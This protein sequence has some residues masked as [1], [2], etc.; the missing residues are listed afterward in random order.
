VIE[1]RIL[2]SL[3]VVDGDHQVALGGPRQRAL[4]TVLLVHRNELVSSDRLI[5]ELWSERAP[6]SAIKVVQGYVSNLR[7]VL[8]D[9]VLVTRGHGYLLRADKGQLDSDRFESLAAAGRRALHEG[10]ARAAAERLREALALW[11]GEPLADCAY[12]TFA[13]PE[14]ARLGESR[15]AAL[16]DRID[17]E[18][19]LGEHSNLVGEL[20]ALVHEHPSR[21]RFESQLMLALYRSGRQADALESYR[22]ARGRM[23]AELGIAPG[24]GLQQL[25][26]AIL[27]HDPGLEAP[28]R[29]ARQEPRALPRPPPRSA[30]VLAAGVA[31]LLAAVALITARL[32]DSGTAAVRAGPN[33][34]AAIDPRSNR[35]V[36]VL[37][38]GARPAGVV[39][40]SG[41]LWVANLD[42]Q[43]VSRI[44]PRT[45]Q[46]LRA[47]VIG[48]PPTAIAATAHRVWVLESSPNPDAGPG[49][50]S[51][52]VGRVDPEFDTLSSAARIRN[53]AQ[54]GPGALAC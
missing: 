37:S 25:E 8:G 52:L 13:Q 51:V 30:A 1:F 15:M 4:L 19:A 17:A 6:P 2:G 31:I 36:D 45:L 54:S 43:T 32:T 22:L 50:T 39:F 33:S 23:A 11:R 44:D 47:I 29:E 46:T 35:V 5:D 20:E 40:G 9:G 3:E 24:R 10:D 41:S 14:I 26:R 21:E 16:E 34:L 42:D 12:D 7:K 49:T 53:V 28:A 38:V 48:R 27:T 18:L